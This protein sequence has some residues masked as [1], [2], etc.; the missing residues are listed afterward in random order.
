MSKVIILF[1]TFVIFFSFSNTENVR[2][3][4][5][6]YLRSYPLKL[7]FCWNKVEDAQSI[8]L[9]HTEL[10]PYVWM[11]VRGGSIP[12]AGAH[13]T[14][15]AVGDDLSPG[16]SNQ[17]YWR[18]ALGYIYVLCMCRACSNKPRSFSCCQLLVMCIYKVKL[19]LTSHQPASCRN[20]CVCCLMQKN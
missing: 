18:E 9:S 11:Q 13:T 5:I 8:A 10:A 17:R 15:S 14:E 12:S 20:N 1:F 19:L 16:F 4:A 3:Q 6:F 7:D 2:W